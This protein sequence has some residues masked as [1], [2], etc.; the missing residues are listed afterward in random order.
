MVAKRTARGYRR[1]MLTGLFVC[2]AGLVLAMSTLF[3]GHDLGVARAMPHDL[4]ADAANAL[5]DPPVLVGHV[6]WQGIPQPNSRNTT[7]P[8]TLTLKMDSTEVNYP[9]QDTA[10]AALSLC[11]LATWRPASIC[12]VSKV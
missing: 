5:T 8:I 12:G 11:R 10:R 4:A 1:H 6:T 7:I 9:A 2:M 3:A